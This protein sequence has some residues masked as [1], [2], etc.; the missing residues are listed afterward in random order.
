MGIEILTV[1]GGRIP[2]VDKEVEARSKANGPVVPG[3]LSPEEMA[4]LNER[5]AQKAGPQIKPWEPTL[6][7]DDYLQLRIEGKNRRELTLSWFNNEEEKLAKQLREWHIMDRNKE[8]AAMSK[9][10]LDEF[11]RDQYLARRVAG[12]SR[13]KIMRSLGAN[14]DPFYA[15]L[16][17]WGIKEKAAEDKVLAEPVPADGALSEAVAPAESKQEIAEAFAQLE[18]QQ[19]RAVEKA[20]AK[21][22]SEAELDLIAEKDLEIARLNLVVAELTE[23]R[24]KAVAEAFEQGEKAAIQIELLE[25]ENKRLTSHIDVAEDGIQKLNR[26]LRELDASRESHRGFVFLRVPV[27]SGDNPVRQRVNVHRDI[28]RLSEVMESADSDRGKVAAEFFQLVQT[29]V[30][31]V[32]SELAELHPGCKDVAGYVKSFFGF[33][34]QRHMDDAE[35]R[36]G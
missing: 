32:A 22:I 25:G 16:T 6:S 14:T 10:R 12:E 27:Q 34:N 23:A 5:L 24:D 33:H 11:T 18:K 30:A 31:L 17:E 4:A 20:T 3:Q 9:K 35:E 1:A 26:R 21:F 7:K 13:T 15:K 36:V 28:E 19:E 29:Y 2:M 8:E